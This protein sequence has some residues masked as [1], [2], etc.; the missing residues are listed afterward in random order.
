[1]RHQKTSC[2]PGLVDDSIA[3]RIELETKESLSNGFAS[4]MF[5][6]SQWPNSCSIIVVNWLLACKKGDKGKEMKESDH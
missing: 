5:Y 4:N 3:T 2:V 6:I 1:M